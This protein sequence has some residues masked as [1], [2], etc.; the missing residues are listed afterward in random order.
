MQSRYVDSPT[1]EAKARDIPFAIWSAAKGI[2]TNGI[3]YQQFPNR[4]LGVVAQRQLEEGTELANVPLSAIF[5]INDVPQTFRAKCKAAT[6]HTILAAFLAAGN[7]ID[8]A[9]APWVSTWPAL[10]DF[11]ESMPVCWPQQGEATLSSDLLNE[12][13]SNHD[14]FFPLPPAIEYFEIRADDSASQLD[15][16]SGL[17]QT[18]RRKLRAGWELV[19]QIEPEV[20]F[21][22]YVYYWLIVNTRSFYYEMPNVRIQPPS[23]DCMVLCPF[24]DLFNHDD[25]IGDEVRVSYGRHNNDF[26]LVECKLQVNFTGASKPKLNETDGFMLANNR[27]DSTPV[28]HVLMNH[29]LGTPVEEWLRSSGYLGFVDSLDALDWK[30]FILGLDIEVVHEQDKANAFILDQL[31]GP[32]EHEVKAYLEYLQ[33]SSRSPLGPRQVLIT[34]WRQ[35]QALLQQATKSIPNR[36]IGSAEGIR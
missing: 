29:L 17:L 3:D 24:I 1:Q 16:T 2:T 7:F 21:E 27:W 12:K 23:G 25:N 4:G 10:S 36:G 22:R 30:R 8:Q 32:F 14:F 31:L 28:D 20:P 6:V 34:R 13:G 11:R 5:T 18:Q 33:T 19:S 26:L 9:H 15:N 35:I